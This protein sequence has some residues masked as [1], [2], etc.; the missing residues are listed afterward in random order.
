VSKVPADAGFIQNHEQ[1][2]ELHATK[3]ISF[4]CVDC[5][6]PHVS[7]H[8]DNSTRVNAIKARCETCHFKEAEAFA[9]SDLPHYGLGTIGC[10]ECHMTYAVKSAEGQL[11]THRGDVRSHLFRINTNPAAQMFTTDGK[12]ANGYLTLDYVCLRCHISETRQW[13]E[14][15]AP[16]VHPT[17]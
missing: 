3:K 8:R 9:A 14:L 13:A 5:H 10:K 17:N 1:Y 7:L 4:A 15:Y 6:D 2:N 16:F 12:Y 11:A